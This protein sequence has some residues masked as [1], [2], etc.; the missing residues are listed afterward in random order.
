TI[1]LD[2]LVRKRREER[3]QVAEAYGLTGAA[4]ALHGKG[5]FTIERI[6][7]AQLD[8]AAGR[9]LEDAVRGKRELRETVATLLR[10]VQCAHT[11]ER[12][13]QIAIGDAQE[14]PAG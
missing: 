2:A 13:R 6:A 5:D 4:L 14:D 7:H 8:R 12:A 3:G 1:D 11:L 9:A 10:I